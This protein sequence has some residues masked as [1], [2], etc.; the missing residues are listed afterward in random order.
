MAM[1]GSPFRPG[2]FY[3][4]RRRV[5]CQS[6]LLF[7]RRLVYVLQSFR[8]VIFASG[9]IFIV[10]EILSQDEID[11]IA[12]L[13]TRINCNPS[14]LDGRW[15]DCTP[16]KIAGCVASCTTADIGNTVGKAS[17]DLGRYSGTQVFYI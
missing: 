15:W 7:Y 14:S 10:G 16:C 2:H 11:P 6:P 4:W 1:H 3:Q 5:L 12:P 8:Y 9:S 17:Y 13:R